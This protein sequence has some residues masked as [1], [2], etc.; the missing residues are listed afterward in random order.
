[1]VTERHAPRTDAIGRHIA[2]SLHAI[3]ARL[4][5]RRR[6]RR[7]ERSDPAPVPVPRWDNVGLA[8]DTAI[9][10]FL[11]A[12]ANVPG[13]ARIDAKSTGPT[14]QFLVTVAGDW[15]PVI[16]DIEAELYPLAQAGKLPVFIYEIQTPNET[17]GPGYTPLRS[18]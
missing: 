9:Y 16:R 4:A 2:V 12:T 7:P 1:M 13:I 18:G 8:V 3:T 11:K 14:V 10:V 6:I 5:G 15:D 17:A